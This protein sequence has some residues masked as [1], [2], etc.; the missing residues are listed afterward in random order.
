MGDLSRIFRGAVA[1]FTATGNPNGG[2]LPEWPSFC[3]GGSILRVDK[4]IAAFRIIP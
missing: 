3:D 4:Q 1:A 2:T